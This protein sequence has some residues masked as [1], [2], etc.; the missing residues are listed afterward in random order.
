MQECF[1]PWSMEFQ[2][3]CGMPAVIAVNP[4]SCPPTLLSSWILRSFWNPSALHTSADNRNFLCFQSSISSRKVIFSMIILHKQNASVATFYHLLSP[5]H[6]SHSCLP[7]FHAGKDLFPDQ[8]SDLQAQLPHPAL[9]AL[10]S[11]RDWEGGF[12]PSLENWFLTQLLWD[13]SGRGP[14]SALGWRAPPGIPGKLSSAKLC[15][16]RVS[17]WRSYQGWGRLA[18]CSQALS[19]CWEW[20]PGHPTKLCQAGL[21]LPFLAQPIPAV[22]GSADNPS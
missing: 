20:D 21:V 9:P 16:G 12:D 2:V 22:P 7:P 18:P 15:S 6:H 10:W 17:L 8:M 13:P 5:V 4:C 19:L 3:S 11:R 14:V 1:C